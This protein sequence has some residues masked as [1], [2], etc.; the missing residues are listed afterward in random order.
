MDV[1]R[2]SRENSGEESRK[3]AADAPVEPEF[4]DEPPGAYVGSLRLGRGSVAWGVALIA[5]V[6]VLA[7]V[8]QALGGWTRATAALSILIV[9]DAATLAE[10]EP[11]WAP[12]LGTVWRLLPAVA[13]VGI[14]VTGFVR[15]N[16]WTD[17]PER[18]RN[19]NLAVLLQVVALAAWAAARWGLGAGFESF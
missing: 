17:S 16:Q 1:H 18:V 3:R 6:V 14:L 10:V 15:V 4:D 11:F 7:A 19:A 5:L 8:A 12:A 13:V 9:Q 2:N